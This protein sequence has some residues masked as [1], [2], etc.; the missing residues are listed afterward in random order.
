MLINQ[1]INWQSEA[2]HRQHFRN[3][4]SINS[5]RPDSDLVAVLSYQAQLNPDG[6]AYIFLSD[7]ENQEQ[8]INYGQLEAQAKAIAAELQKLGMQGER[9]LLLYPAG[10]DYI[11]AFFG[12]LYAGVI[13]V[14]AY[15]PSRHHLHRLKAIIHDATPSVVLTT[16]E[17]RERLHKNHDKTWE[18]DGLTWLAT[19][20][21][22]DSNCD[23]WISYKVETE[24]LA[25]LQYTSGST[26]I[27]KV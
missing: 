16:E 14:P 19:N 27:P 17:L 13:A 12:C 26:G 25:F 9:A 24:N 15:P 8:S 23:A 10:L 6:L 22:A 20:A 7:G 3:M 2:S 18:Y 11:T 21:L 5:S 4:N 1:T